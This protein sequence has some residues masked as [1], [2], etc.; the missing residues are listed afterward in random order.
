MDVSEARDRLEAAKLEIKSEDR[1]TNGTGT[2]LR[3]RNNR[4]Q[5]QKAMPTSARYARGATKC[6]PE[7]V[8][9]KL[10]I[11]SLLVMFRAVSRRVQRTCSVW[12]R[13]SLLTLTSNKFRGRTR[14]GFVSSFSVP[15]AGIV[16]NLAPQ[17]G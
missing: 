15:G 8:E 5:N 2:Q 9:R 17:F 7:Q 10:Y 4:A 11:A 14:A 1:L 3:L 12:N 6:V 13:L 16:T